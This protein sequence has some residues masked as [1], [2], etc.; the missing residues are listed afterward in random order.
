[1]SVLPL[2]R[3]EETIRRIAQEYD[4]LSKQLQA[5]ARYVERNRDHIGIEGIRE[6]AQQCGVQP[7]AIVRFAKRFGFSGFSEL[8][9]MFRENLSRQLAPVGNYTARIRS[10]IEAANHIPSHAE[11]ARDFLTDSIVGLQELQHNMDP[12]AFQS[13]VEL[14]SQSDCVWITASRRSFPVAAYMEYALQHTDKRVMLMDTM[15]GARMGQMHAVRKGD[16]M[17]AISFL[18]YAEETLAVARHAI[19]RGAHLLVITDSGLCP[20]AQ[21]ANVAL[22]VHE[23]TTLGFRS[24]CS[25][26]GLA[27]S[28]VVSLAYTMEISGLPAH[29][30][31]FAGLHA[32]H[33]N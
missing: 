17:L 29:P 28:L 7:S 4:S 1:M 27:Q 15:G 26:M 31:D 3:L 21:L 12:N 18:P 16:V 9:T 33:L 11:V 24:L 25:A 2:P 23:S 6:F 22:V 10:A 30:S 32:A 14:L 8:Q 5:I 13:A 19:E 20:L